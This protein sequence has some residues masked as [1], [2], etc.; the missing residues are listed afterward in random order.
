MVPGRVRR[1]R[2]AVGGTRP[3]LTEQRLDAAQT[4][5]RF[6]EQGGGDGRVDAAAVVCAAGAVAEVERR[7]H[8]RQR[9]A[10]IADAVLLELDDGTAELRDRGFELVDECLGHVLRS[11]TTRTAVC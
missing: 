11:L 3:H 9:V 6:G 10:A 1:D 8:E 5:L 2:L 4:V 7:A